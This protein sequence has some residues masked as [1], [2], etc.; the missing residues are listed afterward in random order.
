MDARD[1]FLL[2]STALVGLFCGV[3]VYLTVFVP[4][5][6]DDQPENFS[7]ERFEIIGEAYGGCAFVGCPS[8][9]LTSDGSFTQL[10]NSTGEVVAGTYPRQEFATLRRKVEEA[11]LE[12]LANSITSGSDADCISFVDGIDY[13]YAI[14]IDGE[15][16]E[17]D[18]CNSQLK[19]NLELQTILQT[20]F[21][22]VAD[23]QSFS[24]SATDFQQA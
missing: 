24:Y 5:Y 1:I 11:E 12:A 6:V 9:R 13:R 14:T 22:V 4:V 21:E 10:P 23:P 3:Y 18:T 19:N 20:I 7:S 15:L 17:L 2:A 8:F 16:F